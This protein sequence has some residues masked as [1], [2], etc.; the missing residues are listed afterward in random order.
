MKDHDQDD[1][2]LE[3]IRDYPV[4]LTR[5]WAAVTDPAEIVKWFG[6]EGVYLDSCEMD[7]TRTGPWVCVMVG[8]ESGDRFKVSGQVTSVNAPDDGARG[9]VGFTWAWHDADDRRGVESFVT[10]TVEA[11]RTGARLTLTHR[12]LAN[13]DAAQSHTQGWLSTLR[14]LDSMLNPNPSAKA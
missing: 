12:D 14:K 13:I 3:F 5:L 10:F 11:T 9:S 8:R 7:L 1:T 6:P 2:L 4:A